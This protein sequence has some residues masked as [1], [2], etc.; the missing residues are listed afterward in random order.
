MPSEPSSKD[1]HHRTDA[2]LKD[3]EDHRIGLPSPASGVQYLDLETPGPAEMV[4]VAEGLWWLRMPLPFSLDHI[5]LYLL[6]DEDGWVIVDTGLNT[7]M[8]RDLWDTLL[9]GPMGDVPVTRVIVTHY[10]PDH[11]G[12]AGWLCERF[13]APLWMSRADFL[14]ARTLTLDIRE[15]P[16]IEVLRFYEQAGYGA[17]ALNEL[18]TGGWGRFAKAVS[19]L[20]LGYRRMRHGDR[21]T[22]GERTWIAI[23]GAGHAPE[24]I[25]L[26]CPDD[27][28]LLSGDQ[29]LPRITSN[30]SV[31]PTEPEGNPL[32][33]WLSSLAELHGLP[34]DTL[35]FPSHI[36]PFQG[37]HARLD[38]I[39]DDHI[40]KLESLAEG[41]QEPHT[42]VESFPYLFRKKIRQG[43]LSIATG[44]AL[45]HLHFL[46]RLGVLGRHTT[47]EGPVHFQTVAPFNVADVREGLRGLAEH[48]MTEIADD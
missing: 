20:P 46:E 7:S 11:L 42:A 12:L 5:N 16:P 15:A 25:C 45:A 19:P 30:V 22:I 32:A 35:V 27:R 8:V 26:Y 3:L 47:G 6:E 18:K 14:L 29:V 34:E 33:D 21:F 1:R 44:E 9:S 37:L 39:I 4:K 10:H 43:E 48:E 38:A 2:P 13:D 36:K 41:L 17:D 31:F 23:A 28:I 24:H 40:R